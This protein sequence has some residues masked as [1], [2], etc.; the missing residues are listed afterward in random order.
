MQ[1]ASLD[2]LAS[3]LYYVELYFNRSLTPLSYY[4]FG[5]FLQCVAFHLKM[6]NL[7]LQA[8]YLALQVIYTVVC[9]N[10]TFFVYCCC[11]FFRHC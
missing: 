1:E 10:R 7:R 3:C 2:G 4:V 5:C 11:W 8:G 9:L 6:L